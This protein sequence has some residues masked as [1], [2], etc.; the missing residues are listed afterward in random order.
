MFWCCI[1]HF[2]GYLVNCIVSKFQ[3]T[4]GLCLTNQLYPK[5]MSIL[6]K[7]VTVVSIYSLCPLISSFSGT[8]YVISPFLVPSIL[9]T[10]NDLSIGFVL[11]LSS[12]TSYLSIS[13]WVQLE[14]T[15]TFNCNSFLFNILIFVYIFNS[16]SLLSCQF[17]ITSILGITM[18]RSSLYHTYFKPITKL[19][20]LLLSSL[21]IL[22]KYFYFLS[23]VL[24]YGLLLSISL[25]CIYNTF[26]SLF[27]SLTF[28][29]SLL[30]IHIC[31]S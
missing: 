29:N 24:I 22:P 6:F 25:C 15:S 28:S 9:K 5:N 7:F 3:F 20:Y 16:L 27:P 12:F 8:N 10:L 2:F 1:L 4:S 23:F 11:V 21:L 13:V 31:C 17:G 30:C 18:Y 14:F 19:F 26:L